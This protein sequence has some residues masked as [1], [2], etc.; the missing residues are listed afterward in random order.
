VSFAGF[1]KSG[2]RR[3]VDVVRDSEHLSIDG[4]PRPTTRL[5][6]PHTIFGL[7]V[8]SGPN[9][10][11]QYTDNRYFWQRAIPSNTDTDKDA[12]LEFT[13]IPSG[14]PLFSH[15][16]ATNLSESKNGDH[17][18]PCGT[19]I[20]IFSTQSPSGTIRFWFYT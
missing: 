3:I 4:T 15:H 1:S 9:G 14:S 12:E 7:I 18:L 6:Q 10:E 8:A 2:V 16:T 11:N 20:V 13:A 19:P 17:T 5:A